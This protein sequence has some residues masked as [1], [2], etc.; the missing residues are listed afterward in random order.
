MGVPIWQRSLQGGIRSGENAERIA[1]KAYDIADRRNVNEVLQQYNDPENPMNF[2][3]A[4]NSIL[5][6]TRNPQTRQSVMNAL[7]QQE[8]QRQ[9]Q[10]NI[11]NLQEYYKS[12][13][14]DSNLAYAPDSV[15]K[16]V[17]TP[18]DPP[19]GP[20]AQ[21]IPQQV[22]SAISDIVKNNLD[23]TADE[24]AV[25]FD[26]A[27]I[28]RVWSNSFIENR[29]RQDEQKSKTNLERE[30]TR[31]AR[32][33][34]LIEEVDSSRKMIPLKKMSTDQMKNALLRN[35]LTFFSP[36]NVADMTG[37]EWLRTTGGA[38]FKTAQK[39][40][41]ISTIGQ[42]TGRPNQWIEQ[43]IADSYAKIGRPLDA[44]LASMVLTEFETNAMEKWGQI[45]DDLDEKGTIAP[46]K[47]GKAASDQMEKW[48]Q[49]EIRRVNK[50]IDQIAEGKLKPEDYFAPEGKVVMY[51]PD[52]GV[53]Y[54][55]KTEI[56]KWEQLGAT[57][58]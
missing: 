1:A 42:L 56:P 33:E 49:K 44:N 51:A 4:V 8:Q 28:P 3:Q 26:K 9:N 39:N 52:G 5:A 7:S 14:Q 19:G 50:T 18:K 22:S 31:T 12:I 45:I 32:D 17:L 27:G 16:Q 10:N 15:Q 48:Y 11:K 24:L 53:L 41:L 47:L 57:R 35:D 25:E 2:N 58:G 55:E 38:N 40:H 29:R 37:F 23:S 20:T 46:G 21:P 43:Q 34:K 6:N 13:G 54:V 30:K 36:D